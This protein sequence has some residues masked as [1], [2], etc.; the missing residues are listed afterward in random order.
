MSPSTFESTS[1]ETPSRIV[2]SFADDP[3]ASLGVS[4][5]NYDRGADHEIFVP[6]YATISQLLE[7]DTIARKCGISPGD[8]IVAVNGHEFRRFPPTHD[9]K[10]VKDLTAHL[11]S[12]HISNHTSNKKAVPKFEKG[13]G[14]KATLGRIKEVKGAK[15]PEN[16]LVLTLERYGWNTRGTAWHRFLAAR[17]GHVGFAMQMMEENEKWRKETFPIDLKR[18]GLQKIISSKAISEID[19][20]H[21]GLPPT[22]YVDFSKL[23]ALDE[24]VSPK[25]VV[26]AFVIFTEMLL[27]RSNDPTTPKTCQFID[28]SE[29]YISSGLRVSILKQIYAVFEPNYPETLEKMIMYPVSAFVRR[30]CSVMLSFVNSKTRNK[31]IITDDLDLVCKELGWDKEQ[32]EACGGVT[33]FMHKHET[34]SQSLF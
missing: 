15:D 27:S 23:Q 14:Y 9:E 3:A 26:D 30:T 19:L 18:E 12:T 28:L 16:P 2:V 8:C 11:D 4:L 1:S 22:V 33:A 5:T 31:F 17:D 34:N 13:E 10:N 6:S 29:T 21:E 7:G 20:N 24:G 32:I 25:D